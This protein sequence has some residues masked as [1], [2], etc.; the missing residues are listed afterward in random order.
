MADA[1]NLSGDPKLRTPMSRASDNTRA[2]FKSGTPFRALSGNV[3][4]ANV[5]VEDTDTNSTLNFNRGV[6]TLRQSGPSFQ[7]STYQGALSNGALMSFQR[8]LGSQ[9]TLLV[10]N[11]GSTPGSFT[12]MGLATGTKLRRLWP[13]GDADL[14]SD[15]SGS[16]SLI[17]PAQSFAVFSAGP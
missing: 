15:G 16:V 13:V 7:R 5:A 17:Q 11:Y 8:T 2:G 1:A 10:F 9:T 3:A 14:V 12:A 4:S 6:I